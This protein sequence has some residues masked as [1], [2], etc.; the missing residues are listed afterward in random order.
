M[1][2]MANLIAEQKL[3]SVSSSTVSKTLVLKLGA[4]EKIDT[5]QWQCFWEIHGLHENVKPV[6]SNEN[7]HSLML[8]I[9]TIEQL[10]TFFVED[11]GKLFFQSGSEEISVSEIIPRIKL[12]N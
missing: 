4:P 8:A 1:K 5:D 6:I 12:S 2:M 7:W 10:L 9:K 3:W 11:G